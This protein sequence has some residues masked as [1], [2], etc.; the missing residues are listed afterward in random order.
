MKKRVQFKLIN[1]IKNHNWDTVAE[2]VK[3]SDIFLSS[4]GTDF[5]NNY[6]SEN[7]AEPIYSFMAYSLTDKNLPDK[8]DFLK[9]IFEY[10]LANYHEK[11]VY[12]K[13]PLFEKKADFYSPLYYLESLFKRHIKS[14]P[15][16]FNLFQHY[17]Q[18]LISLSNNIHDKETPAD[19]LSAK[20][21]NPLTVPLYIDYYKQNNLLPPLSF[22]HKILFHNIYEK[23]HAL[24]EYDIHIETIENAYPNLFSKPENLNK[25][26]SYF[27]TQYTAGEIALWIYKSTGKLTVSVKR[28]ESENFLLSLTP[29]VLNSFAE[30]HI[31]LHEED[32]SSMFS[33]H[34]EQKMDELYYIYPYSYSN[35]SAKV[36]MDDF[37]FQNLI[38]SHDKEEERLRIIIDSFIKYSF[39]ERMF[40][41]KLNPLEFL[42]GS[43]YQGNKINQSL[44]I[45]YDYPELF[46]KN[47]KNGKNFWHSLRG[48]ENIQ[49]LNPFLKH[50][51]IDNIDKQG[52][53]A[54]SEIT[55][56]A[57]QQQNK[58]TINWLSELLNSKMVKNMSG[59]YNN[60][61]LIEMIK[62]SPVLIK[63][64]NINY[65]ESIP[66]IHTSCY[67]L[68]I[69]DIVNVLKKY[70]NI[71]V[72]QINSKNETPLL[73]LLNSER[74]TLH[75]YTK[76]QKIYDLIFKRI[77][78][79]IKMK[80]NNKSLTAIDIYATKFKRG[81]V[82]L[83]REKFIGHI[84]KNTSDFD[85]QIIGRYIADTYY[86]I[87]DCC[88]FAG[89]EEY[90]KSISIFNQYIGFKDFSLEL[91]SNIIESALDFNKAQHLDENN[92]LKYYF[93]YSKKILH[94]FHD[95]LRNLELE[96]L[97]SYKEKISKNSESIIAKLTNI[98]DK[99]KLYANN[100]EV[101]TLFERVILDKE[102][103][104]NPV[105]N[106]HMSKKRL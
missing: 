60:I 46:K 87:A 91:K 11:T 85:N 102:I 98:N 18:S 14:F 104:H 72:N 2:M 49:L 15:E 100:Q 35:R 19:Y 36:S 17:S 78:F 9:S 88:R 62:N 58:D 29:S 38:Y 70:D 81:N 67:F 39:N 90:S 68:K 6:H 12:M 50:G 53:H 57:L 43:Q 8:Q 24:P 21:K 63:A 4:K 86:A 33:I 77:N 59:Q 34:N 73:L 101:I 10:F 61:P 75:A 97:I 92:G 84:I 80:Y 82:S 28:E 94:L 56:Y 52:N 41:D 27:S 20:N 42:L 76:K 37:I 55:Y 44:S 25:I 5:E 65:T 26:I 66:E 23:N 79:D 69:T 74:N 51:D 45:L 1:E 89:S 106:E 40:D 22:L 103:R 99:D 30:N 47:K 71:D 105:I 96:I 64:A 95:I 3:R 7:Y 32:F 16:R 31:S 54:F 83:Q 48:M 13:A 93:M